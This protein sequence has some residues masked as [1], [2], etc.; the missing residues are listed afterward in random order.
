MQVVFTAC[1][2]LPENNQYEAVEIVSDI[3]IWPVPDCR[4]IATAKIGVQIKHIGVGF[5]KCRVGPRT[6]PPKRCFK[7]Q[8]F[9]HNA[10]NPAFC[11]ISSD[12]QYS[13]LTC[14]LQY[15]PWL[16]YCLYFLRFPLTGHVVIYYIPNFTYFILWFWLKFINQKYLYW[17]YLKFELLPIPKL[18]LEI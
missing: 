16:S 15:L 3:R 14:S 13:I 5:S 4:Q 11:L 7:F 9:V 1:C 12:H 17:F 2:D 6:F 18:C 8:R 10:R